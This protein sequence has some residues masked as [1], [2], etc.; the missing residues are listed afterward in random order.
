MIGTRELLKHNH[1]LQEKII[2]FTLSVS[3]RI[4]L[5]FYIKFVIWNIFKTQVAVNTKLFVK[6]SKFFVKYCKETGTDVQ[7]F[8]LQ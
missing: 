5:S 2:T 6:Y 7:F 1:I 3:C 4:Y 8:F